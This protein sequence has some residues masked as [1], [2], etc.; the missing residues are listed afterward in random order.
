MRLPAL[1]ILLVVFGVFLAESQASPSA[2]TS[3]APLPPNWPGTLEL[4]MASQP[5]TAASVR[6]IAPFRFRYQYLAGGAN[7]GSG[8]ATWNPNGQFVTN[9][10][11]ESIDNQITPAFNSKGI[12]RP[13][14]TETTPWVA[15]SGGVSV[16][17]S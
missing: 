15:P 12:S 16:A 6:S 11:Q 5:G 4:G 14:S 2:N 1:L 13:R 8:W 3:A 9:Y 10:I 7:T 17:S